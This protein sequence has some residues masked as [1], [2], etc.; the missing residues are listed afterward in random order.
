MTKRIT[1]AI[2]LVLTT[3]CLSMA[4]IVTPVKWRNSVKMTD[5]KNGV[6]TFTATIEKGWHMYTMNIPD[7]GPV[8]L[9]VEWK[10]SGVKLVGSLTPSKAPHKENDKTF[11]MVLSWWTGGVSLSQKFTVT[12]EKYEIGGSITSMACNEENCTPPSSEPFSFKGTVTEPAKEV[13]PTIDTPAVASAPTADSVTQT[14]TQATAAPSGDLW[15]PVDTSNAIEDVPSST[16]GRSLWYVFWAC[17]LGGMLALLTPCVWPMIPMTV[18]FFL[19]KSG[20]RSKSIS[21]AISY[22]LSI[23]VIFVLL[24]VL[25]TAI[26]GANAL[27][28]MATN[29]VVNIVFFLLLVVFAISFFGAFEIKLPESWSNKMDS[30]AEKTTGLLSIFFMAATLVIVSFSCTGPIIGTLLV[31]AASQGSL[32]GPLVG[33]TG[34]AIALAIPFALFALFPSMLKKLPKSGGWLNTVKVVLGFCELALALKFLSVADLAYG[35]HILDR[36]TFL[37]L[38]IA[39]FGTMGLY[40]LGMFR[41]ISDGEPRQSGIGVTRFM[42]A[43]VSLSFT[44]Y[45]IPGLWGAPLKT[46]S[47]FVP[48]LY[49]QDF[50][51]YGGEMTEYDNY[52]EGMAEAAKLGKPVFLDFSGFGCVNCRK[53][54][55]SVFEDAGVKKTISDEFITIKLMVDDKKELDKPMIVEENGKKRELKTVGDKWSYLQRHKF[56]SNSQPYYVVLDKNGNMMSGPF[57]YKEDIPAFQKFLDTGVNNYKAGA[58]Q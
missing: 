47:A 56:N 39:I 6:V 45:L 1:L 29:A 14:A 20:S 23:I 12:G 16:S 40:L 58:K 21:N 30:N 43:L 13:A 53:M 31:E 26:F 27:N 44:A 25:F 3:V 9:S 18:S 11:G 28:A 17:F 42:L 46:T 10:N 32:M 57:A 19:K 37:A 49:T 52:E 2:F 15:A 48:P 35:W 24:G 50:N 33:M 51:L 7:G 5:N 4:Q 38:W 36:E 55:G 8:P 22:G 34:F 54:E 41:F